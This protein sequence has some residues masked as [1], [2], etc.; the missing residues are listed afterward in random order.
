MA[1][2]LSLPTRIA[3][4]VRDRGACVY[5]GAAYQAGAAL[6]VDHVVSRKRGGGDGFDNLVT[7]CRPCN[8]DKA[9][10]SLGAYLFELGD[11]GAS[12]ADT[13][14]VAARVEAARKTPIAWPEVESALA[15]YRAQGALPFVGDDPDD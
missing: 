12:R 3:V 10:F 11:R 15:L 4:F 14:A 7:A 8:E 2:P 5:C 6:T 9:H 13:Q 1:T